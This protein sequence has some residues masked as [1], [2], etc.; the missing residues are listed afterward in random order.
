M[1]GVESHSYEKMVSERRRNADNL[2]VRRYNFDR[3]EAKMDVRNKEFNDKFN[4]YMEV[5]E[6]S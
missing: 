2:F 3:L 4:A 6:R 1:R 5:N